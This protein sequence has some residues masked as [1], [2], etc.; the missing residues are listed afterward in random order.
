MKYFIKLFTLLVVILSITSCS[1]KSIEAKK[2]IF[3]GNN[4]SD[5]SKGIAYAFFNESTGELTSPVYTGNLSKANFFHPDTINNMLYFIGESFNESDSSLI[6][7]IV[8]YSVDKN[9]GHIT[10][11]SNSFVHGKGPCFI[12]YNPENK[13]ILIANYV[14]G[15]ICS[16]DYTDSKLSLEYSQQ[17]Y[18][19]GPDESRQEGPHAHSIRT[20][21]DKNYVYSCDLG[22]DKIMVYKFNNNKLEKTDS[23]SCLP[24]A[25]PRHIDFSP[26]KEVMAV[27][28]ELNCTVTTY[29]KDSLSIYSKE[30]QTIAML[31]DTFDGFAKAADIHFS[32]DGKYLYAS[33]RGL[34]SIVAYSVNKGN[35][36]LVEIFTNNIN[37]PRNFTISPNGD[38]LLVA[39][40]DSNNISV[41]K[42]DKETGKLTFLNNNAKVES[43][44]CVR[45]F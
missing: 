36:E 21:P 34:N 45:F 15:N 12:E 44:V 19:K 5:A 24:G 28:N 29:K 40:R 37:W 23:I 30:I 2:L 39:N 1:N 35:L 41:F 26:D 3:I 7:S 32:P 10:P 42:R 6:Q 8:N 38:F 4:T 43:P 33:N 16:F 14:S 27:V 9:T 20:A 18:G 22:A 17:H 11:V 13:K 25:G 31:P